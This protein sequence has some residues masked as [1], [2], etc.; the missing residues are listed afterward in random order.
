MQPLLTPKDS[1]RVANELIAAIKRA[2]S[3]FE[4]I[5]TR[6][7]RDVLSSYPHDTFGDKLIVAITKAVKENK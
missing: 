4:P 2:E 1:E 3:N 5:L 7:A 6:I